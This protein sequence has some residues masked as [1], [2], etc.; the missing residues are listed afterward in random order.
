MCKLRFGNDNEQG[1]F[2]ISVPILIFYTKLNKPSSDIEF[3]EISRQLQYRPTRVP[4]HHSL[5][6]TD[7]YSFP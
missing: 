1:L 4:D 3:V 5:L 2:Q 6:R 7:I